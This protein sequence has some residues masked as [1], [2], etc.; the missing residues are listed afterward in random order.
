MLNEILI[1]ISI[2]FSFGTVVLM[3]KFLKLEGLYV[4]ISLATILAN[5]EVAILVVAFGMEQTLG[6][7]LFASTFLATDIISEFYGKEKA[8]KAV[9]I[10]CITSIIFIVFSRLWILYIPSENDFVHSSVKTLFTNTPRILISSL[11]SYIISQYLDV[12]LYH[13]WWTFTEKL[14][15]SKE[16]FLWLRN[17]G[18]TLISQA[19]NITLFN[20]LAFWSIYDF[21]TLLSI[22]LS[23]YVIYIFTSLLDTPFIYLAKKLNKN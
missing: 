21:K 18:S 23:C 7:A 1:I 17:N 16:K 13:K 8:K 20:F 10:G 22:T 11:L 6:N 14:T 9:F 5:I 19:V 2:L 3:F 12:W 4:W 15:K